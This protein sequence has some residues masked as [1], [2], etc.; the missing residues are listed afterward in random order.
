MP[1]PA[2]CM[3]H[4]ARHACVCAQSC[5]TLCNPMDCSLP[6]SS[7]HSI[8]PA[9]IWSRLPFPP[10]GDLPNPGI[11]PE[12]PLSAALVRGFFYHWAPGKPF[13]IYWVFYMYFDKSCYATRIVLWSLRCYLQLLCG[14]GGTLDK[15]CLTSNLLAFSTVCMVYRW[16]IIENP[17]ARCSGIL[18][19]LQGTKACGSIISFVCRKTQNPASVS[20]NNLSCSWDQTQ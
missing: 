7:V 15:S 12:S 18:L 8:F 11:K 6:G 13:P 2:S 1:L 19:L 20:G 3:Q 17:S 16:R 14:H 10:L 5:L 4:R 9:R